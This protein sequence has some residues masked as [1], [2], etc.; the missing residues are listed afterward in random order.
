MQEKGNVIRNT[1]EEDALCLW[2]RKA[3]REGAY[4]EEYCTKLE[5]YAKVTKNEAAVFYFTARLAFAL[6]EMAEAHRLAHEAYARRKL[7]HE[8]WQL[9]FEIGDALGLD[10]EAIFFKSLCQQNMEIAAD[11]PL[12][13]NRRWQDAFFRGMLNVQAP[14]FRFDFI[15]EAD[16]SPGLRLMPSLGQFLLSENDETAPYRYYCAAYNAED[17]FSVRADALDAMKRGGSS[18]LDDYSGMVFDIVKAHRAEEEAAVEGACIV[19]V[20]ATRKK[21]TVVLKDGRTEGRIYLGREE[22]RF[23]RFEDGAEISS[24]A[25]FVIGAPI[26][27]GHSPRR[28][29]LVLNLLLDGLSW[30][31]M[32]ARGFRHVPNLMRFFSD[33]VIFNN[34]YSVPEYTFVSLG[35]IETGM[36]MHRS[37]VVWDRPMFQLDKEIKTISEQMKELGYHCVNVTGDGR[38]IYDGVTRGFDRLIVNP[39]LANTAYEGVERAIAH[40]EAFDECDNYIWLHT[41]DPHQM[42]SMNVP[43]SLKSQAHI[44]WQMQGFVDEGD[45][46]SV[47]LPKNDVYLYDNPSHIE[48]MDRALGYLFR[49]IEAHYAPDEYVVHAYSDHGSPAY[50]DD[51]WYFSEEQCGAALMVRG[52]GV[53]RLGVVEELTS[54]LDIYPIMEKTVGFSAPAGQLDGVLPRALGGEGRSCC[55]SNSIYPEQTYKLSIRTAEYEFRLETERPT[56]HDGT[57]DMSRF[58]SHIYTRDAAHEEV[59]DAALHAEF[60]RIAYEHT[61]SFHEK[62]EEDC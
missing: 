33:G 26:R 56:H 13:S 16:G 21:Q 44:P 30:Q 9:L 36:M 32:R 8:V 27:L 39:Y 46:V 2:L 61:A 51:P 48:A 11:M 14:P 41:C 35:T 54:C 10:E 42:T 15:E 6:G 22:F 5:A 23:L 4:T 60:L 55:I 17:F 43:L 37:Q 20:A 45:G 59:F 3:V 12:F 18:T 7:S 40:L 28:R 29:K 49:Y 1:S 52:A 47:R 62:R 19:P 50:T 38:G 31:A 58:A 25:P 53:P 34:N 57:V 24:D